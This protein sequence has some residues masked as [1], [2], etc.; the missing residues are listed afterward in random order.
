MYW[1]GEKAIL[2][3]IQMPKWTIPPKNWVY[4]EEDHKADLNSIAFTFL[5]L[6]TGL[7]YEKV[8][9]ERPLDLSPET[10][11][12]LNR[13]FSAISESPVL[14]SEANIEENEES[15]WIPY[16]A[17]KTL[18]KLWLL[19]IKSAKSAFSS[20]LGLGFAICLVDSSYM[21]MTGGTNTAFS[22]YRLALPSL[23]STPTANLQFPHYH[24]SM[25]LYNGQVWT[26]G[27]VHSR[28]C[29]K[30]AENNWVEMANMHLCRERIGLTV[31]LDRLF[32]VGGA[33]LLVESYSEATL[34]A[35]L[36]ISYYVEGALPV[37]AQCGRLFVLG[38][39]TKQGYNEQIQAVSL[40]EGTV[41][42]LECPAF[43]LFGVTPALLL[44]SNSVLVVSNA[45]KVSQFDFESRSLIGLLD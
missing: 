35:I 45:G 3:P 23:V 28:K 27:G 18:W 29:E 9:K 14:I 25:H 11:S 17:N 16:F 21:L 30:F 12:F 8:A 24:H 5:S 19:P 39:R 43:G 40:T 15:G 26:V 4:T 42:Q 36:S 32:A 10:Q 1:T 6:L 44:P 22:V 20:P 7:S 34:W 13:C 38:G 31:H 37:V 41:E 33:D 2:G